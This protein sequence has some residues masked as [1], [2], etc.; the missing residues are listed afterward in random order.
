MRS[1]LQGKKKFLSF[2][3]VCGLCI[4]TYFMGYNSSQITN[5]QSKDEIIASQSLKSGEEVEYT[6]YNIKT[7]S[8][9]YG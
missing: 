9:D 8:P 4:S 2:C 5:I 6:I 1:E 7:E 3:L